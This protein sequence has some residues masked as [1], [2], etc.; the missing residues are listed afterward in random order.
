MMTRRQCIA[1]LYEMV[2]DEPIVFTT[3][4]T[5]RDAYALS[6]R[7]QNFYMLGSMGLAAAIGTGISIVTHERVVVVDGDGSLLMNPSILFVAGGLRP[8]NL[9]H[10]VLDNRQYASTGGQPTGAR[11]Y[12]FCSIARE[13]GYRHFEMIQDEA[14]FR[15]ELR[16]ALTEGEGPILI[17]VLI[18]EGVL[19]ITPRVPLSLYTVA[20]RLRH[21]FLRTEGQ[22][23]KVSNDNMERI[24]DTACCSHY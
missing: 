9:I 8:L 10:I 23:M 15:K 6:D 19:P 24:N 4:Y 7:P 12:D 22:Q 16:A 20:A 18:E 13:T 17:H 5:C 11:P 2:G 21:I 1:L 3:G 14:T